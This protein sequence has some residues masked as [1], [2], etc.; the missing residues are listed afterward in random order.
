[1]IKTIARISA[2]GI[3]NEY[4][5][6]KV[7][8]SIFFKKSCPLPKKKL[9]VMNTKAARMAFIWLRNKNQKSSARA[10]EVPV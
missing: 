2:T 1:M 10:N 6:M 8:A 5:T 3:I 7:F 9:K 4:L